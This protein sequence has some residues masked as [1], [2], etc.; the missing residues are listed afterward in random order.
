MPDIGDKNVF[1]LYKGKYDA[2]PGDGVSMMNP[3]VMLTRMNE[4]VILGNCDFSGLP[5]N[6]TVM[7]LPEECRP[8][9]EFVIPVCHENN[10]ESAYE[11]VPLVIG[12]NGE[13]TTPVALTD[14][15]LYTGGRSFNIGGKWYRREGGE[16]NG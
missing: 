16:N 1:T 8:P 10:V 6:A 9:L 12:M 2:V 11:V 3:A 15:I 13:V 14:G 4:V 5:A 7:T